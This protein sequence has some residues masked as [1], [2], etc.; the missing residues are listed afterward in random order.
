MTRAIVL[1]ATVAVLI[2]AVSAKVFFHEEFTANNWVKSENKADYGDFE[3]SS[4]S[5]F[6]GDKAINQ[7]LKTSQDAKF[8]ASSVAMSEAVENKDKDLVVSL[9]VKHEQGLDC[10]GGY[11]KVMPEMEQTKFN[12]DSEYYLMFGPDQCGPTKKVHVIFGYKGENLLW[13]KTPTYPV[14]KLTHVYTLEVKADNTYTLFIDQEKKE[15]GSLE[16]DWEFLK[17]KEIDDASEKKPEDWVDAA[18]MADPED[19]KPENYDDE[20]ENIVDPEAKQPADWDT[21]EDGEWEAP[22][23]PNPKYKGEWTAKQIPNPAYK[24]VWA[25]Q[26]I[27]N[28]EYVEDKDLYL[29]QKP[30][31]VIGIDVWQVKSGSIFDNIVVGDNLEEVNAIVDK[32]WKA[33]KDAEKA[34]LEAIEAKAAE[35]AKKNAPP[36]PEE[37][38]APAADAEAEEDL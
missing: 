25:A 34:A 8:Y 2:G 7:G 21:E 15:S 27:A 31:K 14:D 35:E 38:A 3:L 11:I 28:P 24:G 19:T 10:G 20:A 26:K 12:G 13:K 36:A 22:K 32:T 17:P 18:T 29:I 16:E 4:G 33:T 6:F 9:S 30:L 5:E 23:V 1:A 37:D